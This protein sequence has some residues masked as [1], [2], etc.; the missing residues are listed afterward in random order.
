MLFRC[1]ATPHQT[2]DIGGDVSNSYKQCRGG[3][4]AFT[5]ILALVTLAAAQIASASAAP[6]SEDSA[7][8]S[9]QSAQTQPSM[10]LEEIM[11]TARKREEKAIDVP[12][13][14]QVQVLDSQDLTQL[15]AVGFSDYARTIAGVSFEDKGA[16]RWTIFMRGV[17]TGS[18]VD[19]G[20]D[21]SVGVYFDEI[22][23]AED[24]SQPDLKL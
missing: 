1:R 24:S 7:S 22:P 20:K 23:I 5:A 18:D 8:A 11:V 12:F 9:E 14:L 17:S 10:L 21:S 2:N 19:T 15:G 4:T 13:S 16:G 6:E 3:G